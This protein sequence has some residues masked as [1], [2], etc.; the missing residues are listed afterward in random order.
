MFPAINSRTH[1]PLRHIPQ[2]RFLPPCPDFPWFDLKVF[3]KPESSGNCTP[4]R[5]CKEI[6]GLR[7]NR[8][9]AGGFSSSWNCAGAEGRWSGILRRICKR[10]LVVGLLLTNSHLTEL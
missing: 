2:F 4:C 3:P 8:K 6:T 9:A 10:W 7:A 1:R 5:Q